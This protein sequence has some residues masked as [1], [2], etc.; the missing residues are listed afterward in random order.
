MVGK[1][2]F[3]Y[4]WTICVDINGRINL[5]AERPVAEFGGDGNFFSP[6]KFSNDLFRKTFL[7]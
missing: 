7:F 3:G 1:Y 6:N 5:W 4:K 2:V